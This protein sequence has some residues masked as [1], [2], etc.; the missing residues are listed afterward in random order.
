[1]AV[2]AIRAL[3]EE[4]GAG[5]Y[6]GEAV[7]QTAHATQ[8]AYH[9]TRCGEPDEV[10]L[11]ALL[12][13]VGHMLGMR[14]PTAHERMGDCGI[15]RHE[16]VG[17]AW[18]S[19]LGLPP[20]TCD[21]VRLHVQAKRFLCWKDPGY[22]TRLSPASTT[23]LGFQGGPMSDAEAAAFSS[24]ACAPTILR[25]RTWDEA[26]KVPG[27]QVPSLEDHFPVIERLV[28]QGGRDDKDAA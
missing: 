1:M 28:A 16:E 3:F 19:S 11:A 8:C 18:L 21:L 17:A 13:D 14:E 7:S 20:S 15:M 22:L 4:C 24:L 9:A 2:A 12:H 26:A 23:T 25:M 5:D 6:V 27:M 10:V